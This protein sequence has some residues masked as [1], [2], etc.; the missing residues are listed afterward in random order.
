MKMRLSTKILLVI[1]IV[2]S[3]PQIFLTRYIL[4]GIKPTGSGFEFSFSTLAYVGLGFIAATTVTSTILFFRFIQV[5]KLSSAIFFSVFPLTL[6]YGA[7]VSYISSIG[8][9]D[10]VVAQSVRATLNIGGE[11]PNYNGYLWSGV[12][13][14]VYLVLLFVI[15]LFMCRPVAKVGRAA[16]NLSQGRLKSDDFRLG[17]GK[18]FQS[19]EHS[20]NRIN[21]NLKER[22]EK[23]RKVDLSRKNVSKQFVKF[24]GKHDV[25]ELECGHSVKKNACMLLCKLMNKDGQKEGISLEENFNFVNSCIKLVLP[26]VKKYG[27][28]VD[29]YLGDGVLAVFEGAEQAVECAHA[30]IKEIARKN[31]TK[32]DLFNIEMKVSLHFGFAVF[33][34][35]DDERSKPTIVSENLDNL[36]KIQQINDFIGAKMLFSQDVVNALPHKYMLE[37][38]FV[39]S[40]TLD[41]RE[42]PL[43]ESLQCYPKRKRDKLLKNKNKFENAVQAF[44][45]GKFSQAKELF[46]QILREVPDDNASYVYFNNCD[47]KL[48]E[49]V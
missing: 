15:L 32:V 19:I 42:I 17:G 6:V 3:I 39:G 7:F 11:K 9:V 37:H 8:S 16:E 12:A 48:K 29:K 2:L 22:S 36:E 13:T 43:Y 10:G 5:Q 44:G 38:R 31:R 24:M 45:R 18:Q 49:S 21:Y 47:E 34:L 1:T 14:L 4:A 35:K 33:G 20:L 30:I 27:G 23:L 25:F 46:A 26:I 41:E 28:F 40:V